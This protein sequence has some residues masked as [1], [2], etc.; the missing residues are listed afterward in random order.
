MN[1]LLDCPQR[2]P[3]AGCL[4][5]VLFF[6]TEPAARRA[7]Q[8]LS[9]VQLCATESV[10]LDVRRWCS[11][12][13]L[14]PHA[15]EQ[16]CQDLAEAHVLI[17]AAD[18]D[19]V[20]LDAIRGW[21]PHM[22]NTPNS[23]RGIVAVV[24]HPGHF[25]NRIVRDALARIDR[26][27][28]FPSIPPHTEDTLFP[29]RL[30]S[31][32][33]HLDIRPGS[34]RLTRSS[35]RILIAEDDNLVRYYCAL[36]LRS[37]GFDVDTAADGKD[38]WEMFRENRYDLVITDNDMPRMTGVELFARVRMVNGSVPVLVI[39]GS[40]AAAQVCMNSRFENWKH[41]PK[42]FTGDRLVSSVREFVAANGGFDQAGL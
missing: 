8:L 21:M 42:P 20:L 19:P 30:F 33:S 7:A 9:R 4:R 32:C 5:V 29:E 39:S 12:E 3:L 17:L 24:E 18:R 16:A 35:Q 38:A 23:E 34:V 36:V 41:L 6:D 10:H 22:T 15:R 28:T 2:S 37:T 40:A 25:D 31:R 11:E 13:I 26:E 14:N 1:L 27:V